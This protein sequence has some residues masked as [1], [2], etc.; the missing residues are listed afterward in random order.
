VYQ[1]GK[2]VI[3]ILQK[4]KEINYIYKEI[5]CLSEYYHVLHTHANIKAIIY[6]YHVHTM[7]WL[8]HSNI[9]RM[10]KNIGM[11]HESPD[12]LF[13][14][15]CNIDPDA[16]ETSTSVSLP[17]PI[18][19]NIDEIMLCQIPGVSTATAISIIKKF[20]NISNLIKSLEENEKCLNDVTNT[21][22]KGQ[23]RKINKSSIDNIVN[24]L[25]KK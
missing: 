7:S 4:D 18:Y 23:S 19:E 9:Q 15:V 3:E 6:N 25:L 2:R 8:T 17:R 14:I 10:I 16:Y 11:P 20:S 13:D 5:D 22:N 12:N 24:F 1:Y 21:N